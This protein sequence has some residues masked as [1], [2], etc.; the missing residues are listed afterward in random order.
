MVDVHNSVF[1]IKNRE[2]NK[3]NL[4]GGQ[5]FLIFLPRYPGKLLT[6]WA[7]FNFE[8]HNPN[9]VYFPQIL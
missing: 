7:A 6:G 3:N 9:N 4:L 1:N 8:G 2:V 5:F